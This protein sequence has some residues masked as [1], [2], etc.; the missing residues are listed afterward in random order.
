MTCL[1]WDLPSQSK[2][3]L[4]QILTRFQKIYQDLAD[5][6]LTNAEATAFLNDLCINH[7]VQRH[8]FENASRD[9]ALKQLNMVE[10]PSEIQQCTLLELIL[11]NCRCM[12]QDYVI[13]ETPIFWDFPY[14][15]IGSFPETPMHL[16]FL[17]ITKALMH[18]VIH[19]YLT[20]IARKTAFLR[21]IKRL[22]TSVAGL[23][24]VEWC[25]ALDFSN[26]GS[27]TGAMVSENY[28]ACARLMCWIFST[29]PQV[30]EAGNSGYIYIEH[31]TPIS[32]G[33]SIITTD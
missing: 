30:E 8:F 17:G 14:V 18:S 11:D 16:L 15:D 23:K 1:S 25:K 4:N 31:W 2:L 21:S 6:L 12:P 9:H 5:G 24:L 13:P 20:K 28:M 22:L 7:A 27:T 32:G 19:V 26:D 10:N 29:I 33:K 3:N